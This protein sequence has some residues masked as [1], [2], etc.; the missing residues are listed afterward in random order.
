MLKRLVNSR[1]ADPLTV[2]NRI[3]F[4]RRAAVYVTLFDNR[5]GVLSCLVT[6][7]SKQISYGGD[8]AFPGG[9]ADD[10]NES[11][12]EVARREAYEEIRFP[13]GSD[14]P[15]GS[16]IEDICMLPAYMSSRFLAVVP[17]VSYLKVPRDE[18]SR[19]NIP[20]FLGKGPWSSEVHSIF[21]APLSSFLTPQ[22]YEYKRENWGGLCF[23]QHY[24]KIPPMEKKVGEPDKIVVWGL[25][26][27]ILIDV[28]RLVF[29]REP[30]MPHRP[31]G[32]IG[33]QDLLTA[34]IDHGYF[35]DDIPPK[36]INFAKVFAG[37]PLLH[38]RSPVASTTPQ[39]PFDA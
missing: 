27:N 10:A 21:T 3:P 18:L 5:Q 23:H 20:K 39:G 38:S 4:K 8:A 2:W 32:S 7:R 17:C 19:A 6:V 29:N 13:L 30:S 15:G 16:S 31:V 12:V 35:D 28:A 9:K 14:L 37:D 22:F 26:A 1:L 33:D 34:L 25:T 24:I 11:P 36:H